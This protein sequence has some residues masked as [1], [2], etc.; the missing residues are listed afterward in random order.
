MLLNR[1][2][3]ASLLRP[4]S[5]GVA[6]SAVRQHNNNM[7]MA[8]SPLHKQL[9]EDLDHLDMAM[10]RLTE[11]FAPYF[12][13]LLRGVEKE[14][15]VVRCVERFAVANDWER[16]YRTFVEET[17]HVAR[18]EVIRQRR[19]EA[20]V[21]W[22]TASCQYCCMGRLQWSR[23]VKK[24][25]SMMSTHL[26]AQ[27]ATSRA[28][29]EEALLAELRSVEDYC[30]SH[31]KSQQLT[32]AH[33]DTV[34]AECAHVH[35]I[36]QLHES[37]EFR[38]ME[39]DKEKLLEYW[40]DSSKR[41]EMSRRELGMETST[42]TMEARERRLF[43]QGAFQCVEMEVSLRAGVEAMEAEQRCHVATL[44]E[45]SAG[46]IERLLWDRRNA[47]MVAELEVL[48]AYKAEAIAA[49][50]K[51][52]VDRVQRVKQGWV[53]EFNE[54]KRMKK[55][56][57]PK[58]PQLPPPCPKCHEVPAKDEFTHRLSECPERATS[59]P[60]CS[61]VMPMSMMEQH[62]A[63]CPQRV[64][65]CSSGCGHYYKA[66]YLDAVHTPVYCSEV[67]HTT[68]VILPSLNADNFTLLV[69]EVSVADSTITLKS[70][71]ETIVADFST[72]KAKIEQENETE[73]VIFD[74]SAAAGTMSTEKFLLLL[75]AAV[76]NI[77][78][79]AVTVASIN[80][81]VIVSR[82]C[83]LLEMFFAA[84]EIGVLERVGKEA[85]LVLR[86]TLLSSDGNS[87][88]AVTMQVRCVVGYRHQ[89]SQSVRHLSE[90]LT[91]L[92]RDG[93]NYCKPQIERPKKKK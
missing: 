42:F 61:D 43:Q 37:M 72:L 49:K 80:G 79:R 81:M 4:Y 22:C 5:A 14:E 12:T 57:P 73:V 8:V 33:R 41:A 62:K 92:R 40:Y 20:L 2:N 90:Q 89:A 54:L 25:W 68:D 16:I 28:S 18:L 91:L 7:M 69:E 53:D 13:K 77:C 9:R 56:G 86:C 27:E 87:E 59:C 50:E 65:Q 60:K 36:V 74:S 71:G 55:Q 32:D 29:L 30:I 75:S 26:I 63:T 51:E 35:A 1:A 47:A 46:A 39:K 3:G 17:E 64:L 44:R 88:E 24:S 82:T 23:H 76:S 67:R 38:A 34:E 52:E 58:G 66:C 21:P 48:R 83:S 45:M 6:T 10:K 70:E 84:N 93:E 31:A 78:L 15:D 19:Q 11:P 85:T